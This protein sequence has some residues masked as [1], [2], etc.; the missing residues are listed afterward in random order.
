MERGLDIERESC[1]NLY[2][3]YPEFGEIFD[4]LF[5]NTVYLKT[6]E[7]I[8]ILT[9]NILKW[10]E[11]RELKELYV[12]MFSNKIGSEQ[13][14]YYILKHLLPEHE[15]IFVEEDEILVRDLNKE[16]EYLILDDWILSGTNICSILD[17]TQYIMA[18]G[19]YDS[20]GYWK[21]H[22]REFMLK[23]VTVITAISTLNGEGAI[24]D[25]NENVVFYN[26]IIVNPLAYYL[27]N[28]DNTLIKE[29]I[30]IFCEDT[31]ELIQYPVHLEYKIAN[32]FGSFPLIY[33][34]CRDKPANK[35]FMSEKIPNKNNL[36]F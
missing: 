5:E 8:D 21:K 32:N 25:V 11:E 33:N 31:G 3:K 30:E 12:I 6:T 26:S 14:F 28:I 13:Y 20:D 4:I 23:Y 34:E 27:E 18:G 36:K 24:L 1:Q 19:F 10:R 35:N 9:E 7:V 22:D 29:F 15:L 2:R 17:N 16:A